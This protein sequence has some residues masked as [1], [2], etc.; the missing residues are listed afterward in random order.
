M[1]FASIGLRTFV[2]AMISCFIVALCSSIVC[3]AGARAA[4]QRVGQRARGDGRLR[5]A[6]C[7]AGP[8]F[9]L[10]GHRG[11]RGLVPE[12]TLPSFERAIECGVD[13]LELD[14]H[15][16]ADGELIVWHDPEIDARHC[17]V[18]PRATAPLPPDPATS[19]GATL[20]I[21]A[22]TARQLAKYRC[23]RNPD[24]AAHPAQRPTA[25]RVSGDDFHV[26]TLGELFDFVDFY[27][28]SHRVPE[29]Y[30]LRARR[31]RYN[32]ETKRSILDPLII[33]DG[34]DR[35]A[36]A[37]PGAFERVLI[38]LIRARALEGR[39]TVQ[40]F[41]ARSLR[42]VAELS[43]S[44]ERGW[45]TSQREAL[46]T[47]LFARAQ[48]WSPSASL[49]TPEVVAAA[50]DAGLRVVAWTVNDPAQFCALVRVGVDGVITDRPD[51]LAEALGR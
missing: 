18:D 50:H 28:R 49:V 27:S 44:V 14:L 20:R 34:F 1:R 10:Q 7:E 11:A 9:E 3:C 22:L 40:S 6:R 47:V 43:P 33:D 29:A 25:G 32:V 46:S 36:P 4:S 37:S 2:E 13:T 24:P 35:S 5:L 17:R 19:P 16:S 48:V 26:V 45:L 30:R 39:V 38:S 23:D 41:D 8:R 12:S 15:F 21:R 51:L 42:V 31:V